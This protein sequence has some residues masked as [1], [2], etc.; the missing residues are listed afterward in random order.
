MTENNQEKKKLLTE[1][2]INFLS[3]YLNP[4]S[5]TFSN[6]YKSALKAK[7][8]KEY[9]ENLTNLMPKWLSENIGN[10]YLITKAE[11]NLREFIEMNIQD[12]V[13]TMIG[14]LKDKKGNIIK[15]DN[16]NK[17]KIKADISKFIL[18]R[19]KK[20]KY[21]QK[22]S[23]TKLEIKAENVN[24][25]ILANILKN[26]DEKTREQF[27]EGAE[28]LYRGRDKGSALSTKPAKTNTGADIPALP[29][30]DSEQLETGNAA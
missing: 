1:K 29:K 12:P 5:E 6:V 16:V 11:Q 21:A 17:M 26:T 4:E 7:Y 2:Q 19:L 30:G 24:I 8:K 28:K 15:K 9:A 20:E 25:L 23:E 10:L 3:F 22:Q 14:I 27:F 13:I 18:E